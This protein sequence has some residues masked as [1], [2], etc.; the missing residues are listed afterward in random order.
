MKRKALKKLENVLTTD[1]ELGFQ[2]VGVRANA[3]L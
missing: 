1:E 2:C 3:L